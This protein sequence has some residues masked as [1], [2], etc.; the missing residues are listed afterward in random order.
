MPTGYLKDGTK[1]I[2]PSMLGVKMAEKTKKKISE[3][4]IK[5]GLTPPSR[6]GTKRADMIGSK[7]I[8]WKGGKM[9]DYPK[10]FQIRLSIDYSLW[11]QSVFSR[12]NWKCQK[13]GIVGGVLHAHHIKNFRQFP[14]LRFA[15]DNGIT[16]STKAHR[17]F[18]KIYGKEDNTIEQMEEFLCKQ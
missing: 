15:I 16:L 13:Y 18:H 11:R 10:L 2:P 7:N 5:S 3:A 4:H 1:I 17:E 6:L 9:K 12:D 14:E 8:F